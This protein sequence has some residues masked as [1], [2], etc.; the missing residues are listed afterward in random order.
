MTKRAMSLL[1]FHI[2]CGKKTIEELG[3]SVVDGKFLTHSIISL[4]HMFFIF[5]RI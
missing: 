5:L 1:M 3:E 4:K 2:V